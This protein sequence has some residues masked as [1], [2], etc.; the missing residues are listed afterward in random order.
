MADRPGDLRRRERSRRRLIEKRLKQVMITPV[1]DRDED[2][3]AG[4]PVNGLESAEPGAD[5]DDMMSVR[6]FHARPVEKP[7]CIVRA[8]D[9]AGETTVRPAP[10]AKTTMNRRS[11]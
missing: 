6:Q 5:H 9:G 10:Y 2:R 4:Q 8:Q 1:D 11:P 7:C 3:R